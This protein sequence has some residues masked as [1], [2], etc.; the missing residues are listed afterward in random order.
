MEA[1]IVYD[2]RRGMVNETENLEMTVES[3]SGTLVMSTLAHANDK[4]ADAGK[5]GARPV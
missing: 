3:G 1:M 2:E 4:S 5:A